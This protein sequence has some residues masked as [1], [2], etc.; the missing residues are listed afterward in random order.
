M[1][2]ID[3][4]THQ[5]TKKINFAIPG[6]RSESNQPVGIDIT[7]TGRPALSH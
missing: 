4:V 6:L 3:P 1:S 2:I 7:R 5:V